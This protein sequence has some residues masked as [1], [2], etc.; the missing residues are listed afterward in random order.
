MV[1]DINSSRLS[2]RYG[3][4]EV[5]RGLDLTVRAGSVFALL[6]PNG[7][8][9]TTLVRILATLVEPDAGRATV[10]G[11]DVVR[12]RRRVQEAISLTG[13][14]TAVDEL[15]TGTENLVMAARLRRFG[16]RD[17]RRRAAELLDEFDLAAAGHRL[18][19]TYSG[20]MRRRL[21]LAMSLVR[22]P[23]VLFL[24]E[25]TTGLDP[26]SRQTTWDAVAALARAGVTV[27]LTTQY[28]EE[29]DQLA[30]RVALL[31]RGAIIA[32]G[33]PDE[34]KARLAGDRVELAVPEAAAALAVLGARAA[35]D[36]ARGTVT[37]PTDGSAAAVRALLN[38]LDTHG[39]RVDR[40]A[41]HRPTLDDVFLTLTRG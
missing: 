6:G 1:Y 41:V 12:E 14:H 25:P 32:D 27:L 19:R 33:T 18:A 36:A 9:K 37:V 10:A 4:T 3:A 39:V 13:Q 5:L 22:A 20:G 26:R 2:K 40:V 7:A 23:R 35:H 8:G 17:A 38:T 28:L 30:D 21:D 11:H 24:D 34:L 15:L 31:D 29:A 16:R